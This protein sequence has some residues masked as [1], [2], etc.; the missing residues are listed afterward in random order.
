L[1]WFKVKTEVLRVTEYPILVVYDWLEIRQKRQQWIWSVGVVVVVL[2]LVLL[3]TKH[4]VK[5]M[6]SG[7][8]LVLVGDC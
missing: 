5:L 3:G 1:S 8:V 6:L 7:N 4:W 2:D